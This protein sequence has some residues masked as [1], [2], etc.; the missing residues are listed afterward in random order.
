MIVKNNLHFSKTCLWNFGY[1]LYFTTV[2]AIIR[3]VISRYT[4]KPRFTSC[5]DSLLQ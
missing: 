3:F 5:R 1:I 4:K 2:H